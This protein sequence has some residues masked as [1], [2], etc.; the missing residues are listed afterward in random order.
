MPSDRGNE[1]AGMS[2]ITL[3]LPVSAIVLDVAASSLPNSVLV[4][5]EQ[6]SHARPPL[7]TLG[8][9]QQARVSDSCYGTCTMPAVSSPAMIASELVF[10]VA[11]RQHLS[12]HLGP[13]IHPR[14]S[15]ETRGSRLRLSWCWYHQARFPV[16]LRCNGLLAVVMCGEQGSRL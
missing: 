4:A 14:V 6:G 12:S 10:A 5:F 11:P 8:A 9:P 1:G 7:C 3:A 13:S 15:N 2:Y 16:L